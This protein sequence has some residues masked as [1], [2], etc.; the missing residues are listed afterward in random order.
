MI[1]LPSISASLCL[2]SFAVHKWI[3]SSSAL[4]KYHFTEV[5]KHLCGK[6]HG[7][8][9][10]VSVNVLGNLSISHTRFKFNNYYTLN[11]SMKKNLQG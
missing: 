6:Q 4:C 10:I 5:I 11:I 3:R 1:N 8:W 9:S 7:I 2:S